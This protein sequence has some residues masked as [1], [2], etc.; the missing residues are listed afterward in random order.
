VKRTLSLRRETLAE[1][2]PAELTGVVG[3][4]AITASPNNSCPVKNCVALTN[5]VSC[6]IC[7]SYP[8]HTAD[9]NCA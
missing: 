9:A 5:H 2:T 3:G 7:Y 4:Q 6:L 1:L 8:C